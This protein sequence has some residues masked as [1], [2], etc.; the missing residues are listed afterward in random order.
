MTDID[1]DEEVTEAKS[2]FDLKARL[3]GRALRTT[4]IELFTDEVTGE[5]HLDNENMLEAYKL[6]IDA[7][8]TPDLVLTDEMKATL[9]TAKK[10]AAR[11]KKEQPKLLEELHK[12]SLTFELRA[13]PR[14]VKE[15]AT[16][17][18][19]KATH[20]EP[21]N[22]PADK[23]T[24][25]NQAHA[26]YMLAHMVTGYT[27]NDS[28]Q[29]VSH[30]TVEDAQNLREFLPEAQYARLEAAVSDLN[31]R[32]MISEAVTASADF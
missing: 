30:L 22:I 14:I 9:A 23:I 12:S 26:A 10:E 18:A 6:I 29:K 1:I 19:F 15:A 27:D 28:G 16:R 17:A 21:G 11:I 4:T 8:A 5:K 24:P 3:S 25:F 31:D 2:G 13:T 7:S 32:N 20:T